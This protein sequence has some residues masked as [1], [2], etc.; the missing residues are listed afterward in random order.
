MLKVSIVPD[1]NILISSLSVVRE[2]YEYDFPMLCTLN[3]SKTVIRELE[4]NKT[5]SKEARAAIRFLHSVASS[6][7][8]EIEGHIDDRKMEV[9]LEPTEEIEPMN[10]DDMIL[11]YILKLENP[12]F[13]TN[14]LAF[15]LKCTSHNIFSIVVENATTDA[16][17]AEII[18]FF[19]HI[20]THSPYAPSYTAGRCISS[21]KKSRVST[22]RNVQKEEEPMD[23]ETLKGIVD[24]LKEDLTDLVGSTIRSIAMNSKDEN[25]SNN[26]L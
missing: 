10:N 19:K 17:V 22:G 20:D 21:G 1:T 14:D 13:L 8:I 23:E 16:L 7:K 18:E 26:I 4:S 25:E 6:P 24:D 11:N 15:S 9:E 3:I 2:L 12:V 5:R